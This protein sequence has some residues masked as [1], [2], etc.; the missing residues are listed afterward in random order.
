M[1]SVSTFR[2]DPPH[3]ESQMT[4]Y[5]SGSRHDVLS[6]MHNCIRSVHKLPKIPTH[7]PQLQHSVVGWGQNLSTV[8]NVKTW[9]FLPPPPPPGPEI[10]QF[11]LC[12]GNLICEKFSCPSFQAYLPVFRAS[13]GGM[14]SKDEP[15]ILPPVDLPRTSF[16]LF[17]LVVFLD[18]LDELLF[19]DDQDLKP[20][21]R[22]SKVKNVIPGRRKGCQK[23]VKTTK[24]IIIKQIGANHE[25][26][27]M[28]FFPFQG[29]FL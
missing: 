24:V 5:F 4:A 25:H 9:L 6:I 16:L 2:A 10:Y 8:C 26:W 19:H 20:Q 3:L 11:H 14:R 18:F 15:W 28:M 21:D 1:F 27:E 22:T 7:R 29:I 23:I 17:L 12:G 13:D